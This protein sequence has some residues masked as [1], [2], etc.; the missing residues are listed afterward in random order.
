M[1]PTREQRRV[2]L[3]NVARNDRDELLRLFKESTGIL[4]GHPVPPARTLGI[5]DWVEAI[6]RHEFPGDSADTPRDT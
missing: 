5:Q 6:L 2:E 1:K 3:E 4:P